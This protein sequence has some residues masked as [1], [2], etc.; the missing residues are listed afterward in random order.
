MTSER[1]TELFNKLRNDRVLLKKLR[2]L[3][4]L[5]KWDKVMKGVKG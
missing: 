4:F 1:K 2:K 3:E 5:N